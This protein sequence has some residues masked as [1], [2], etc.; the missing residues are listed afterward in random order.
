VTSPLTARAFLPRHV[1]SLAVAALTVLAAIACQPTA[2]GQPLLSNPSEILK[3]GIQSTAALRAVHARVELSL[4]VAPPQ[5]GDGG[6]FNSRSLVEIDVDL[7]THNV[8]AR[9][10]TSTGQGMPDQASD[11]ILFDGRQFTRNA[12]DTRWTQFPNDGVA[13]SFPT[14]DE[15]AALLTAVIDGG[16]ATL[17][18]ADHETCG[19]STCYHVVVQLDPAATWQILSPIL[20]GGP[21]TGPPPAGATIPPLALDVLIDQS[22][23][24]IVGVNAV[25]S[26]QGTTTALALTLT[27][28]DVP[29]QIA[30]PPANLVDQ[31]GNNV[32]GGG[33][34]VGGEPIPAAAPTPMPMPIEPSPV[35]SP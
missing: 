32:G 7:T 30:P 29:V 23:R 8:A 19:D 10:T 1:A 16:N 33:I 20:A 18:L 34:V 14:N 13:P 3:S 2:N 5:G 25:V 17:D 22:T 35:E 12:A 31:M 6:A 9:S 26:S 15:L 27:N 11:M 28:H 21:A 4:Q 24:L